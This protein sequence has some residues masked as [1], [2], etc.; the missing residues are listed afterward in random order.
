MRITRTVFPKY[1]V[2][3]CIWTKV[4]K[5]RITLAFDNVPAR[6]LQKWAFTY[7]SQ[8]FK[9][10]NIMKCLV[11]SS[12]FYVRMIR[13]NKGSHLQKKPRENQLLCTVAEHFKYACLFCVQDWEDPPIWAV[14]VAYDKHMTEVL[15][16]AQTTD[17]RWLCRD[18]P[19]WPIK[20]MKYSK[21]SNKL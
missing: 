21:V 9:M 11:N 5:R 17:Y 1:W 13:I 16:M 4:Y 14:E 6:H 20:S 19:Q 18:L 15:A 12:L 2:K 7:L 3:S 10:E 8:N